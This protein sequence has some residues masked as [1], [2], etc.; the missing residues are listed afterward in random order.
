MQPPLTRPPGADVMVEVIQVEF[1]GVTGRTSYAYTTLRADTV[2]R[3]TT[4][5][6][7]LLGAAASMWQCGRQCCLLTR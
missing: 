2:L 4:Q 5:V 7:A 6:Q 1:G 3:R